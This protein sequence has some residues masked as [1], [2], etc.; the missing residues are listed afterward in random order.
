MLGLA[1]F[2]SACAYSVGSTFDPWGHF[3]AGEDSMV[4]NFAS[5]DTPPAMTSPFGSG[6]SS[7]APQTVYDA[8]TKLDAQAGVRDSAVVPEA[9]SGSGN[10]DAALAPCTAQSCSTGCCDSSGRCQGT[11]D[12]ACGKGGGSCVDCTLT[13]GRCMAG[14]CTTPP[15]SSSSSGGG[16]GGRGGGLSGCNIGSCW[17]GCCQNNTCKVNSDTACGPLGTPCQDCTA[18]NKRCNVLLFAC[19]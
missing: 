8:G 5:M 3:D 1:L 19:F 7:G 18:S 16:L 15:T 6:S 11:F 12:T 4:S 14:S 2:V 13:G 17:Y 10:I 9:A